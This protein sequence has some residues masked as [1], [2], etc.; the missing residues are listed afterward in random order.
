MKRIFKKCILILKVLFRNKLF[1]EFLN[2]ILRVFSSIIFCF[3]KYKIFILREDRLGH[4]IGNLDVEI[5]KAEK[6][7]KKKVNTIFLFVC[8]LK[9]VANKYLRDLSIK[10]LKEYQYSFKVF[11][12]KNLFD[13]ILTKI[14]SNNILTKDNPIISSTKGDFGERLSKP[15]IK[16]SSNLNKLCNNLGIEP[17]NYVCIYS[18][19]SKY[20]REKYKNMNFEYHD[21]R[22]SNIDNLELASIYITQNLKMSVIRIG[23][24]VEKKIYWERDEKPKIVDYSNSEFLNEKNDIDLIAGCKLFINNGGGPSSVAKA[25]RREIIRIN[26]IP[27]FEESGYRYG[28]KIPKLLKNKLNNEYLSYRE[29]SNLNLEMSYNG[30]HYLKHNLTIEENSPEDILDILKD[31]IRIKKEGLNKEDVELIKQYKKI[32]SEISYKNALPNKIY[33]YVSPSFLKK[34]S[35]LLS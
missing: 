1:L 5:F 30:K 3:Y 34:Y 22:N 15:I 13:F 29:I 28:F 19:D 12:E 23:S 32:I 9:D 21:Y 24:N 14:I 10:L 18:R 4:Q 33:N 35:F 2:K 8:P 26:S 25:A 27:I 17:N 31:Y 6:R 20:L 7:K 11:N 16:S